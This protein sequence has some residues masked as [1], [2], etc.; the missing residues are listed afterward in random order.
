MLLY[1]MVKKPFLAI[2]TLFIVLP[3]AYA[4]IPILPESY[5]TIEESGNWTITCYDYVDNHAFDYEY[6]DQWG[7]HPEY[8][9]GTGYPEWSVVGY[10]NS[11]TPSLAFMVSRQDV[12]FYGTYDGCLDVASLCKDIQYEVW[13]SEEGNVCRDRGYIYNDTAYN[14]QYINKTPTYVCG[15]ID[16]ADTSYQVDMMVRLENSFDYS[17]INLNQ[18]GFDDF[19]MSWLPAYF[20]EVCWDCINSEIA[21]YME[22]KRQDLNDYIGF[23]YYTTALHL[24]YND[25]WNVD[26]DFL[27]QT[28]SNYQN[29]MT[30]TAQIVGNSSISRFLD[31]YANLPNNTWYGLDNIEDYIY[32]WDIGDWRYGNVLTDFFYYDLSADQYG[33]FYSY[34]S[35]TGNELDDPILNNFGIGCGLNVLET[36]TTSRLGIGNNKTINKV[37]Y[38]RIVDL[39]TK[40]LYIYTRELTPLLTPANYVSVTIPFVVNITGDY[41]EYGNLNGTLEHLK[42]GNNIYLTERVGLDNPTWSNSA[43]NYSVTI[44]VCKAGTYYY[45]SECYSSPSF[46]GVMIGSTTQ[47]LILGLIVIVMLAGIVLFFKKSVDGG[48]K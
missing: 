20:Y 6:I 45:E 17:V 28:Y 35:L 30:E 44:G 8:E 11:T 37:D 24:R 32:Y 21:D 25:T 41:Y 43:E 42:D 13:E 27:I 5:M 12:V 23:E 29:N 15:N 26:R 4:G 34:N 22:L 7:S 10:G 1:D 9:N 33:D 31:Q 2:L 40:T 38:Y 18:Y 48:N 39:P 14:T 47:P 46:F 16:E 36:G 3:F 19:E